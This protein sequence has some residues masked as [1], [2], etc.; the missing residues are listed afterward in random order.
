MGWNS[1]AQ[2]AFEELKELCCSALILAYADYK[3]KIK[4]HTDASDLGLEAVLYQ[5]GED[6][7]D[8]VIAY[9]GRSLNPAEKNYPAC[10]LEFLALKWAV[11]SHFHEY[12]Y[13]GEFDVYT[14]NNS[15]TYINNSTFRCH[16]SE[17]DSISGQ[18]YIWTIL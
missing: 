13:G 1:E 9:A 18:L 15:L 8:R 7:K 6:G 12:L 2:K 3:K 4:L 17:M 5:Q 16:K 11:T 14:D 10:K